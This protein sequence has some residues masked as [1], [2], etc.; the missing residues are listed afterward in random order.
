MR[1]A[2]DHA[3]SITIWEDGGTMEALESSPSYRST[4][5]ELAESG[6]LPGKPSVKI[7]EVV[8]GVLRSELLATA[9]N[10]GDDRSSS[11]GPAT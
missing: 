8:S 1:S 3:A 2:E 7:L 10:P 6:L 9:L 11:G 4:S 5:R